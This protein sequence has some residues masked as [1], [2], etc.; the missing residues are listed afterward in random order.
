MSS[1]EYEAKWTDINP[2]DF[3]AT[4]KSVGAEL[5]H[6]ETLMRRK[7]YDEPTPFAVYGHGWLRVRDE[8][9]KI[10]LT[11]KKMKDRS[12]TG[13]MDITVTVSDFDQTCAMLEEM[14]LKCRCYQET[15]RETWELGGAEITIDTWPWIPTFVEVEARDEKTLWATAS[16][17]GLDKKDALHG[18][19]ENIYQKYYNVTEEA[20]DNCQKMT[21]NQSPPFN[22]LGG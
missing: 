15:K 2:D 6:P 13:M 12:A 9:D 17:L 19:V 11:Y 21:F 14:T 4:L 8:G 3:R 5:I 20:V 22:K 16:K 1:I 10:T 7:N 18:S